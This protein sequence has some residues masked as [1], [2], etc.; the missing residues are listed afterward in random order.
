MKVFSQLEKAQLEN[1][2]SDT[3][4]LPKG[5][6]TYRT[7]LNRAK[8]SDGS[9][10]HEIVETD[11]AQTLTNKTLTS[12]DINGG[13]IDTAT[14]SDS[15][16][17]NGDITG[18]DI[19]N[20]E[21]TSSTITGSNIESP[22][23]NNGTMNGT[24]LSS[25]DISGS[26]IGTTAITGG[27]ISGTPIS[28]STITTST[29]TSPTINTP[30]I[31]TPTITNGTMSGTTISGSTISTST[32]T[33][34]TINTPT[35]T[36]GTSSGA[37]FTTATLTSPTINTPTVSGGTFTNATLAT[38][39][40]N[41]A[42]YTEQSSTPSTPSAG[43]KKFYAK[44]DGK[45][46]TL[47]SAGEELEVGSGAGT[48][49]GLN[50]ITNGTAD[51][52]LT[53]WSVQRSLVQGYNLPSP[54]GED[55]VASQ[56]E[57]NFK[58]YDVETL[59][60]NDPIIY[61]S[62]TSAIGG[63]TTGTTY[64]IKEL[65]TEVFPGFPTAVWAKVSATP[66]GTVID[67]TSNG[68]GGKFAIKQPGSVGGLSTAAG[69][70]LTRTTTAPLRG[71]ASFLFTKPASN[72]IGDAAIYD[73]TTD[74]ATYNRDMKLMLDTLVASGT[75][76]A[77]DLK[78]FI[79]DKTNGGI[80]ASVDLSSI[81]TLVADPVQVT[82]SAKN[83]STSFRLLILVTN[84][85][86]NA[87]T[88]KFD[89]VSV[90]PSVY[91]Y[92][93]PILNT[94]SGPAVNANLTTNATNIFTYSRDGDKMF[95]NINTTFSGTNTNGAQYYTLN[96]FTFDATK[97]PN[98][99]SL[100]GNWSMRN[101]GSG[102]ISNGAVYAWPTIIGTNTIELVGINTSSNTPQTIASGTELVCN[103]SIP[104]LGWGSSVRMSDGY[105]GRIITAN[106][107]PGTAQ[108]VSNATFVK[109]NLAAAVIDRVGGLNVSTN[110]YDIKT[111][112]DY[113]IFGQITYASNATGIRGSYILVSKKGITSYVAT[114]LVPAVNGNVTMA[115][116]SSLVT[117]EAGDYVE[118]QAYQSSG[119]LLAIGT[120]SEQTFL[121]VERV[122]G[123]QTIAASE[124]VFANYVHTAGFSIPNTTVSII[125]FSSK[126][127]DTHNAVTT[128]VGVWNFKAPI[129]GKYSVE[130]GL[131]TAG[132]TAVITDFQ[133]SVYV[134]GVQVKGINTPKS[135]AGAVPV[136]VN[137][138]MTVSVTAGQQISI[139]VFQNSGG[140]LSLLSA[141][142]IFNWVTI[143]K[144]G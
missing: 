43:T 128:G 132:T 127:E 97:M 70:T 95:G 35:I 23:I 65:R 28:G 139:R 33:S 3:P 123:N 47:N 1:T 17:Q 69:C 29:L 22:T 66:G 121:T 108:N 55:A 117:L 130:I 59:R 103:F 126:V 104:I 82:W 34:P 144:V 27:T 14:I 78:A 89:N 140:A 87:Y 40:I 62:A 19:A 75:Y 64:Y 134:D 105:D 7:D 68:T 76:N 110:R 114:T 109:V 107:Y 57:I 44:N 4:N 52:N 119:S 96:G 18:S 141:N 133:T 88:L 131:Y 13:T 48:G 12:P 99:R 92:G 42:S 67:L 112:G 129:L 63:L 54:P 90:A 20:S 51:T 41:V 15:T 24:T 81:N 143:T 50:Y 138:K 86:T 100:V 60:V 79:V 74:I 46:Y 72:C 113:K 116:T 61:V 135:S 125:D 115:A 137:G 124:T 98:A 53:G 39:T 9:V 6:V 101:S 94:Q 38:P 122:S 25:V 83:N 8:V 80:V 120:S 31:S 91:V 16:F 111:T 10:L 106:L 30:T 45:L 142:P 56:D 118:L 93:T 5:M 71:P 73:F 49:G 21:I 26:T 84:T 77:G 11:A 58:L 36:G 37:T 2:T 102:V 32:L 136:G 85:A